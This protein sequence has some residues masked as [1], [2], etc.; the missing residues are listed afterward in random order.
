LLT[1]PRTTTQDAMTNMRNASDI[2]P[3]VSYDLCGHLWPTSLSQ[4]TIAPT[5][6]IDMEDT[7]SLTVKVRQCSGSRAMVPSPPQAMPPSRNID[8]EEGELYTDS[9]IDIRSHRSSYS[10]EPQKH[11][12]AVLDS[13]PPQAIDVRRDSAINIK[14]QAEHKDARLLQGNTYKGVA[15]A[16]QC[17]PREQRDEAMETKKPPG[18]ID[19]TKSPL[20]LASSSPSQSNNT[21]KRQCCKGN[22]STVTRPMSTGPKFI[23][24]NQDADIGKGNTHESNSAPTQ[25]VKYEIRLP[26]IS[27]DL[28]NVEKK[29]TVS[30]AEG[31]P[32]QAIE[33]ALA[34][35]TILQA[36]PHYNP[37]DKLVFLND[38]DH[39]PNYSDCLNNGRDGLGEGIKCYPQDYCS[40]N[41]SSRNQENKDTSH[42]IENPNN[43]RDSIS[44][45]TRRYP[46]DYY[47]DEPGPEPYVSENQRAVYAKASE[48]R[49]RDDLN[50]IHKKYP[51]VDCPG[52]KWTDLRQFPPPLYIFRSGTFTGK[53]L[54]AVPEW[55]RE[56][57]MCGGENWLVKKDVALWTE[58]KRRHYTVWMARDVFDSAN[59]PTLALDSPTPA[60]ATIPAVEPL[61]PTQSTEVVSFNQYG[62]VT[63]PSLPRHS[64]KEIR[65]PDANALFWRNQRDNT[66]PREDLGEKHIDID[67]IRIAILGPASEFTDGAG[68]VDREVLNKLWAA[69]RIGGR[70]GKREVNEWSRK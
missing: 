67:T 25:T 10:S 29:L 45:D 37:E 65:L 63:L 61:H 47:S 53:S 15:R 24:R 34:H 44:M 62:K 16:I 66:R 68:G 41:P 28:P 21:G 26:S 3:S 60:S 22:F 18:I 50:A 7:D 20:P 64:G 9:A 58:M 23:S 42:Y 55:Y 36:N 33:L 59:L 49:E 52:L 19:L 57:L 56:E 43:H 17:K 27:S 13:S 70:Y 11:D 5:Q 1:A 51:R 40:D 12:A 14:S 2:S 38:E 39:R 31:V 32:F 48:E 69:K 8:L 35:A 30:G 54:D 6:D 4:Q 46:Q